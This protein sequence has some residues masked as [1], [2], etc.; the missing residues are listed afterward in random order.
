MAEVMPPEKAVVGTTMTNQANQHEHAHNGLRSISSFPTRLDIHVDSVVQ[1]PWSS[2][3]RCNSS[4][5]ILPLVLLFCTL[6][7]NDSP[8]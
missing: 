7:S 4:S 5:M 3:P 2:L 6:Q 8:Q 1:P